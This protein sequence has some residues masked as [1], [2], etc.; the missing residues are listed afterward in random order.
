M[1]FTSK[2]FVEHLGTKEKFWTRLEGKEYL[3]KIGRENTLENCSEKIA[4]EIA[5]LIQLEVAEYEFATYVNGD[6]KQGIASKKFIENNTRLI[7]GNEI[8]NTLIANYD[9]NARKNELS[10]VLALMKL[11]ESINNFSGYLVFDALIG[12]QDRHHENWGF[13]SSNGGQLILA[14]SFDHA[15][16]LAS[17]VSEQEAENRLRTQDVNYKVS[18]FCKKAITPFCKNGKKLKTFEVVAE[19]CRL[20]DFAKPTL[21]WIEKIAE[22]KKEKYNEIMDKIPKDFQIKTANREFIL[23]MLNENTANLLELRKK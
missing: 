10:G 19:L 6:K 14:P 12:N 4:Y 3:F 2:E 9:K 21:E 23:E 17:K 1:K 5:K 22:I 20:K 13:I 11:T 15:S 16:G 8:L 18:H 7:L